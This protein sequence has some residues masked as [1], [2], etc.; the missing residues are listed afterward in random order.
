MKS[1][2]FHALIDEIRSGENWFIDTETCGLHGMP[3]LLQWA[4]DDGP[5]HLWDIWK[6]PIHQTLELIRYGL[7]LCMVGFNL[8]FD[9]FH[10]CKLY[11]S[12][13]LCPIDWIPEEH[14]EEIAALEREAQ[15][16]P[17]LKPRSALDLFL[18]SRKT[19]FQSLMNRGDIR[20]RR[21]P[22]VLAPALALELEKRVQFP[23]IY[24]AR[25]KSK[26]APRWGVYD[27]KDD[28]FKDVV[29]KFAPS[30]GLKHIAEHVLGH[31]PKYHYKDVEPNVF[32]VEL[33]YAPT[34]DAVS[35]AE[36]G[37]EV[38]DGEK[39]VGD[40]WP[41]MI[42]EI[43]DHWANNSHAREYANDDIVYTRELYNYFDEPEGGD[44]DSV[45]ACSIAAVRWKGYPIDLE[46][47]REQLDRC[48]EIIANA[49]LDVNRPSEVRK[50]IAEC[51][52]PVEQLAIEE[53][54]KKAVLE[55]ISTWTTDE[56][57]R[58]PAAERAETALTIKKTIKEREVY[59]KLLRARKFH[60]SFKVIGALSGRMSGADGLNPQGINHRADVRDMFKLAWPGYKLALGDFW[61]FEVTLADAVYNDERLR[62]DLL[63][64]KK[65][66]ALFAQ[67][68]FGVTY[69]EVMESVDTDFDMYTKGKQGVFGAVLYGGDDATL[70]RN[71]GV[72]PDAAKATFDD[73]GKRYPGV[74]KNRE[75]VEKAFISMAQPGGIGTQI[76][77]REPEPYI[78]TPLGY[79]RWFTL[80][81][82]VCRTLYELA[83]N[84]PKHWRNTSV[85]VTRRDREQT[86]SG[87]VSSALYG[88]AFGL[89]GSN[90]RAAANHEIQSFGAEIT[91][92]LQRRIWDLQPHGVHGWIVGPMQVH[93]EVITPVKPGWEDRVTETVRE[94]VEGYRPVVPLIGMDW[95]PDA[96]SWASKKAGDVKIRASE[97]AT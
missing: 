42:H 89:Q 17:C 31:S 66:H 39:F 65:I 87:A 54:T 9:H 27:T 40:A 22:A 29:L 80:E 49:P 74:G 60:A 85:K 50:Y 8:T 92:R 90:V 64:G 19:E 10:L 13:R 36:Q 6:E 44:D 16:G 48:S 78:E 11:T 4:V 58:H 47:I 28:D 79:K 35:S 83:R 30:G 51:M 2:E 76:Y 53:S 18:H 68:L 96:A 7:D 73:F 70:V 59:E 23:K 82:E 14:I 12:F 91:K 86:A 3:V 24:F 94:T 56:G 55:S 97:M 37:W 63:S 25:R 62:V 84:P 95:C 33:G 1:S 46:Q 72:S 52:D 75:K 81:N 34:A 77:W 5:I 71:L 67:S 45:L 69:G 41:G 88:A 32:P 57:E 21:V 26:G 61:S 15:D 43:I 20:I 93:D 38:W